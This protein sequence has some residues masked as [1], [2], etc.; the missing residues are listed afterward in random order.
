MQLISQRGRE[1]RWSKLTRER[2][3]KR[4][5]GD[6]TGGR[7]R[8][9]HTALDEQIPLK[10]HT[11][12]QQNTQINPRIQTQQRERSLTE[13]K[14]N[15]PLLWTH[16]PDRNYQL[17]RNWSPSTLVTFLISVHV[18]SCHVAS[19]SKL[20]FYRQHIDWNL[21]GMTFS[22]NISCHCKNYSHTRYLLNQGPP[23]DLLPFCLITIRLSRYYIIQRKRDRRQIETEMGS[24]GNGHW[25]SFSLISIL[26]K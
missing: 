12:M 26:L 5:P 7:R 3:I 6:A 9:H 15:I 4:Q 19:T 1:A 21:I 17:D 23:F 20:A 8:R 13:R 14:W 16:R 24:T 22:Y 25:H 11:D 2:W 10:Q 18:F